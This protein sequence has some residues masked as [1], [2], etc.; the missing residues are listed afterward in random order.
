[1]VI[2]LGG[3]G[4]DCHWNGTEMELLGGAAGISWFACGRWVC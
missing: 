2:I 1:M 3:V 4:V